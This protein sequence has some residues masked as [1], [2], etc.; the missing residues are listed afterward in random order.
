MMAAASGCGSTFDGA[1]G[2]L[3]ED[4]RFYPPDGGWNVEVAIGYEE[5][6][7]GC[8]GKGSDGRESAAAGIPWGMDTGGSVDCIDAALR[9]PG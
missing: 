6:E 5:L 4:G 2:G 1:T 9:M 7:R 8:P 3:S